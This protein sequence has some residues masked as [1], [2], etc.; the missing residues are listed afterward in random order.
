MLLAIDMYRNVPIEQWKPVYSFFTERYTDGM[1]QALNTPGS[2]PLDI[3]Y[4][5]G[6]SFIPAFDGAGEFHKQI[7]LLD[8]V[9][10]R[11]D[12]GCTLRT[13]TKRLKSLKI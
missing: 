9:F 11:R 1:S 4:F 2:L 6:L 8:K 5:I 3:I 13:W 7:D 10:R 12:R